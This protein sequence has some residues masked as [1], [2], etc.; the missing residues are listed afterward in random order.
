MTG[1]LAGRSILV[2]EDEMLVLMN[3]EIALEE[4]DCT[5]ICSASSVTGS[6]ALLAEKRF[7]AASVLRT[8]L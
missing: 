5:A 1:L 4:L 8:R 6:L 7:D 3:I 2:V